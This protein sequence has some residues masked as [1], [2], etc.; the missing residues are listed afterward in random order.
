MRGQA[1][2]AALMPLGLLA[3]SATALPSASSD[4][5]PVQSCP[6]GVCL[7]A[8]SPAQPGAATGAGTHDGATT[9]VSCAYRPL[10]AAEAAALDLVSPHPE[11]PGGWFYHP[12]RGDGLTLRQ[13]QGPIWVAF[14]TPNDGPVVDPGTLAQEAYRLLPI[15]PPQLATN[16]PAGGLQLVRVAT[17][18]WV[19]R[20]TW[21]TRTA[22][23]SVP[24]ESVTATATP[25][26]VAWSMGDG[27]TVVCQGSGT[28]YDPQRTP[29]AQHPAC[30]YTYQRSS[31]GEPDG[32]FRVSATATW[33][34]TWA[35]TG[36]ATAGG[37]LPPLR[38]TTQLSL[39]VAE[40]QALN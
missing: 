7:S 39:R 40:A 4:Y 12:C 34:V 21:G 30:A 24:G 2:L 35:A 28:A 38:R 6:G 11:R 31:A 19:S 15:P 36:L 27:H 9:V 33:A 13:W 37:Q 29:A 5:T 22:T 32:R 3:Q 20:T 23:V 26:A 16:P 25:V 17:W 14:P 10:P 1:V 18:L 8:Q